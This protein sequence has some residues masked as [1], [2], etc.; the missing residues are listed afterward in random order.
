MTQNQ[1]YSTSPRLEWRERRDFFSSPPHSKFVAQ[2]SHKTFRLVCFIYFEILRSLSSVI[3][4]PTR[5]PF[6]TIR[7][8][9]RER[10][11]IRKYLLWSS[12]DSCINSPDHRFIKKGH[13][14]PSHTPTPALVFCNKK[15]RT[16]PSHPRANGLW[17]K[18]ISLCSECHA[19][20]DDGKTIICDLPATVFH[21]ARNSRKTNS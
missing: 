21:A 5:R 7:I 9:E 19:D 11:K 15:T 2:K 17:K 12:I 10:E 3:K 18:I 4:I 16:R 13:R 1:I 20:H 14:N 8:A 6:L